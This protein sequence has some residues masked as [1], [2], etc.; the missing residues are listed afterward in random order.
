MEI[1]IFSKY[2]QNGASSRYRHY[3]YIPYFEKN[4]INYTFKPLLENNYIQFL[5]EKR[6]CRVFRIQLQGILKRFWFLL[7]YSSKY[8]L[9]IIEKELFPNIPYF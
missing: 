6:K 1:L 9:I 7:F 2:D 4:G 5:Y 3:N 8:D